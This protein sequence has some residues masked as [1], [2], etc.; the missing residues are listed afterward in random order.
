M[1]RNYPPSQPSSRHKRY[2]HLAFPSP[3]LLRAA[4]LRSGMSARIHQL[5]H[6]ICT[7]ALLT[8]FYQSPVFVWLH[9]LLQQYYLVVVVVVVVLHHSPSKATAKDN[10]PSFNHP[11]LTYP[12]PAADYGRCS[13]EHIRSIQKPHQVPELI[14]FRPQRRRPVKNGVVWRGSIDP[15]FFFPGYFHVTVKAYGYGKLWCLG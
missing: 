14:Y 4:P 6:K 11:T 12:N 1:P 15:H 7:R 8:A 13:D 5:R 3:N 2:P 9:N 10:N